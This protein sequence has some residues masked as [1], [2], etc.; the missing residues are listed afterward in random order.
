MTGL[1]IGNVISALYH[2]PGIVDVCCIVDAPPANPIPNTAILRNI[3]ED[4]REQERLWGGKPIFYRGYS[5]NLLERRITSAGGREFYNVA[6]VPD[7]I[8]GSKIAPAMGTSLATVTSG[9]SASKIG[10]DLCRTFAGVWSLPA[11]VTNQPTTEPTTLS[12]FHWTE[13]DDMGTVDCVYVAFNDSPGHFTF[14]FYAQY[15]EDP[16]RLFEGQISDR[17]ILDVEEIAPNLP[18]AIGVGTPSRGTS[19]GSVHEPSSEPPAND[20]RTWVIYSDPEGRIRI[21]ILRVEDETSVANGNGV[22]TSA[23]KP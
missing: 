23:I 16:P 5:G 17:G 7:N 10:Y 13:S 11:V 6:N 18:L 12:A 15:Q 8:S 1:K 4:C 2:Q 14:K 19:I 21:R 9:G 22:D 3:L 20:R